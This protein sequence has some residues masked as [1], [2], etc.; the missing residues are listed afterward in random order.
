MNHRTGL[1]QVIAVLIPM[2]FMPQ[3]PRGDLPH[4]ERPLT[5]D[6][7]AQVWGGFCQTPFGI[8]PLIDP[9][10]QAYTAPV[11]SPCFCGPDAGSVVQ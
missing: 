10:G 1:L 8:C 6:Q 2:S 5:E 3:I 7:L 4:S 9:N 11:G